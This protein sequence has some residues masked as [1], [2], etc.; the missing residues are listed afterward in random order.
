MS[1]NYARIDARRELTR[2]TLYYYTLPEINIKSS[3]KLLGR[4]GSKHRGTSVHNFFTSLLFFDTII[5]RFSITS[6]EIL[7]N[8]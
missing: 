6:S 3:A 7:I 1:V 5:L 4:I 8:I 2:F